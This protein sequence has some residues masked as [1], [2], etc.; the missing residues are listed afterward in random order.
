MEQEEEQERG[1]GEDGED[2]EDGE[3]GGGGGE[4]HPV[5]YTAIAFGEDEEPLMSR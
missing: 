3:G 2:G 4:I 1:Q 5:T